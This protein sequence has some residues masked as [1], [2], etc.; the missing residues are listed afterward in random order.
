MYTIKNAE[1]RGYKKNQSRKPSPILKR[2]KRAIKVAAILVLNFMKV[3]K[4]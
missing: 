3:D 2:I 1:N 4:K